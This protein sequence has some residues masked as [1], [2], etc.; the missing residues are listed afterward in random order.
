MEKLTKQLHVRMSRGELERARRLAD[1]VRILL[2]LPSGTL[3]SSP[4]TVAVIDRG[5]AARLLRE[6]RRWGYRHD[7]SRSGSGA[8]R[9]VTTSWRPPRGHVQLVRSLRDV[10]Q[11]RF[12]IIRSPGLHA[13][14]SDL[15]PVAGEM[16]HQAHGR[17]RDTV[18]DGRRT[19]RLGQSA[20]KL[21]PRNSPEGGLPSPD[22]SRES[23]MAGRALSLSA[24]RSDAKSNGGRLRI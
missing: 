22:E 23:S 12:L 16:A 13:L 1:L 24:K 11:A 6:M 5:T 19:V 4:A 20:C 17:V 9:S 8:P 2:Q 3:V 10:Y 15:F 21:S 14:R 18:Q 7:T